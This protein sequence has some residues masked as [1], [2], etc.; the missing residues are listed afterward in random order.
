M[1][2]LSYIQRV[3]AKFG[4]MSYIDRAKAEMDRFHNR[5]A[6]KQSC[7]LSEKGRQAIRNAVRRSRQNMAEKTDE[8]ILSILEQPHSTAQVAEAIGMSVSGASKAIYRLRDAG[9]IV[10]KKKAHT[11]IWR[12]ADGK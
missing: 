10:G 7:G 4:A 11:M 5:V 6:K 12:R 9:Q 1:T 2:D 8:H 3:N